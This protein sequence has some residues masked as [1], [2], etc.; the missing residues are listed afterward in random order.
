MQ[1]C[2]LAVR[3]TTALTATAALFGDAELFADGAWEIWK[4]GLAPH[5]GMF[6]EEILQRLGI[7]PCGGLWG[8]WSQDSEFLRWLEVDSG[9]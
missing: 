8:F 7:A 2:H 6:E 4:K 9:H 1:R 3:S 5:F